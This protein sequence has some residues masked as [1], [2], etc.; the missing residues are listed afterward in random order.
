MRTWQIERRKRAR[1]LIELG[2]LVVK[3]GVV[4]LSG[5]DRAMI[6]G[7]MIWMP[8]RLNSEDGERARELW[9]GKG[10]EKRG[11]R[12]GTFSRRLTE[13]NRSRIGRDQWRA[14]RRPTYRSATRHR[15]AT[16][17]FFKSGE[18][19]LPSRQDF[20]LEHLFNEE[21]TESRGINSK[22]SEQMLVPPS[23]ALYLSSIAMNKN[24]I[25]IKKNRSQH[26]HLSS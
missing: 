18:Q 16:Q 21:I 5:D 14:A 4:D 10:K 13:L 11:V 20:I 7:A 22:V 6:Y 17:G 24:A 8:E 23:A 9:A 19:R 3:A 25:D 2:G 26:H 12:G 1:H 15:A